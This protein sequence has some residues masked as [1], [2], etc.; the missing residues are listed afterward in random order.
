MEPEFETHRVSLL[1]SEDNCP[2]ASSTG[3]KFAIP[4]MMHRFLLPYD[5][6][7]SVKKKQNNMLGMALDLSLHYW[8]LFLPLDRDVTLLWL[9]SVHNYPTRE[10]IPG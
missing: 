7:R 5:M 8:W 1:R 10:R 3:Y 9:L 2:I 6:L 4:R